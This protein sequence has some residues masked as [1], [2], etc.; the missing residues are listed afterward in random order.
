MK[1]FFTTLLMLAALVGMNAQE[2]VNVWILGNVGDQ[3]WDPSVGTLMEYVGDDTYEY[4]GHFKSSSYFSFT[5]M[6]GATSSDWDIIRPYRFGATFNDFSVEDLLG[7]PIACGEYGESADNAF[8]IVK[9]GN[10]KITLILEEDNRLVMI[11][12]EEE[13]PEVPP[14]PGGIFILGEVNGHGWEPSQGVAMDSIAQNIFTAT[15]NVTDSAAYFGFT[16]ALATTLGNWASIAPYRFAAA[17]SAMAYVELGKGMQLSADGESN[18]SFT[19]AP[20][21]YNIK[22]DLNERLMFVEEAQKEDAMYII[23]NEPF[24]NWDPANPMKMAKNGN[25]Y[26][27]EATINGDVWFIFSDEFG[28]WDAVNARRFGPESADEDQVINPDEDV[29]TQL[30]TGGKSYKITGNGDYVI[31]F[32]KE[33]LTFKFASKDQPGMRGDLT[34]DE[35]VDVDDL[36]MLI[37]IMLNKHDMMPAADLSGD[38]IADVDDLNILIN[39]MLG[40]D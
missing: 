3:G 20:G 22:L 37:N 31:F 40:K 29:T 4:E 15:V 10:Y 36:N 7:E 38:G 34:G 27:A 18:Y 19:I 30:S 8:L 1:K 16:H 26:T 14:T 2:N 24:G 39:I 11:E 28:S 17:D 5:T 6:L 13:D 33:N 32:D 21:Y 9:G 23:G 12:R 25:V 35:V